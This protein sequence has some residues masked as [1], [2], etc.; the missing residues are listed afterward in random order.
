MC[1]KELIKFKLAESIFNNNQGLLFY[2]IKR[3]KSMGWFLE[4]DD[5]RSEVMLGFFKGCQQ[6]DL[7]KGKLSASTYACIRNRLLRLKLKM[8]SNKRIKNTV[9]FNKNYELSYIPHSDNALEILSFYLNG[10]ELDIMIRYFIKGELMDEI[11]QD[12]HLTRERIRQIMDK[13][14]KFLKKKLMNKT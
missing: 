6:L 11:G 7:K 13:T 2:Y 8:N 5:Y 10:R 1:K 12:Y 14:T 9:P 4:D 3:F